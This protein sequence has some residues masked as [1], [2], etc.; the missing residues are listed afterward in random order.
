MMKRAT[1]LA[2][3]YRG[4]CIRI[5]D[6]GPD[7]V[8]LAITLWM[9][10]ALPSLLF[11]CETIS[12]TK[13]AI[14]EISRQQSSVGK[15]NLGLPSCSPNISSS[16]ILGLKPFKELLYAAQLKFYVRLSKQPNARWSKD[17]L[18][19]NISGG[20]KSPYIRMLGEIK[21]EVGMLKWP[22]SNRH[23][24]IVLSHHFMEE[25]NSEIRR[26][27]LPALVPLSKRQRMSHVNESQE[28]Q[29]CVE[30]LSPYVSFWSP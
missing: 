4:A 9:N 12:F 27:Q 8:D 22:I 25:M 16:V 17:A 21:Q 14:S 19:D 28:S 29:V 1:A 23:V 11:G 30:V 20:W 2:N 3:S 26:L 24:D 6:D 13:Q 7:V 10:V 5:A 15:F 18:L